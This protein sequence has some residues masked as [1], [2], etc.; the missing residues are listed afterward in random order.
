MTYIPDGGYY[1]IGSDSNDLT[2]SE[3]RSTYYIEFF[4][5]FSMMRATGDVATDVW[6]SYVES[7]G[8]SVDETLNPDHPLYPPIYDG[9]NDNSDGIDPVTGLPYRDLNQMLIRP[10]YDTGGNVGSFDDQGNYHSAFH[11]DY[12]L[13]LPCNK[14]CV[15]NGSTV[16]SETKSFR[17][18]G[19]QRPNNGTYIS[20]FALKMGNWQP[21]PALNTPMYKIINCIANNGVWTG[22]TN[23]P[24]NRVDRV[25]DC[26]AKEMDGLNQ[27]LMALPNCAIAN[28]YCPE[29]IQP[30]CSNFDS[31]NYRS[32]NERRMLERGFETV[33]TTKM[34]PKHAEIRKMQAQL[35]GQRN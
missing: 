20:D 10:P 1:D 6:M 24:Q 19:P 14:P 21:Q 3:C 32:Q 25:N 30:D 26:F 34:H 4:L 11:F 29:G 27:A 33:V 13:M 35:K 9:W 12:Y 22:T 28:E 8:C 5:T 15:V 7:H 2:W 23:W 18:F 16:A 17:T 31:F